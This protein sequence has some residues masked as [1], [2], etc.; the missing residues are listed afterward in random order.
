MTEALTG[1]KVLD[2][3]QMMTGPFATML[4]GD[5]GADVLKVEQPDGDPFRRSGETTLHGDG[6]FFLGVNR[7][8]RGIVLDL[9]TEAGREA[10]RAL[11]AQADVVVENFRPG[12]TQR[13]GIDYN[14]LRELN[15][16]LVYCSIS[17]FGRTGPDRNRPALDMVIQAVSGVMQVTGTEETGPLKTGFPFS[18]LVTALLATIGILVALQARER[19]GEGQQV[20]LSMLDASIFSQVPRDVYYDLTG[21]TPARMG[22]QHWDLVPNN[23]YATSDGRDVMIITIN[24]KFWHVLC[25]ALGA[26]ELKTDSRFATKSARLANRHA[27]DERLRAIFATRTLTEWEKTLSEAGAIY[28]AVRTWPEVFSDPHVVENLLR[29]VPHPRGGEFKV[30]NNPLNFSGTP[31][32]IRRSPPLLGEHTQAVLATGGKQWPSP[33]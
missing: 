2:F 26:P 27:V 29:S 32:R 7:N 19:T 23:T 20:D 1:L 33:D 17:G 12:L 4:L 15:P 16:R 31:T 3:T 25:D 9:K 13:A 22:N 6:A 14:S 18:D 10:A 28:G 8:K 11:A 30:I 21:K 5:S 24:D